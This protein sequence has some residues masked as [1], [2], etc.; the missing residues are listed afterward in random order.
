LT[1]KLEAL[2][3]RPEDIR[4]ELAEQGK[5]LRRKARDIGQAEVGY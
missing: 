5:V 1:A 2:D 4:K 3:L